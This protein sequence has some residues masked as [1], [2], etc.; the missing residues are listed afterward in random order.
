MFLAIFVEKL[1]L[2]RLGQSLSEQA[3]L[4]PV[5]ANDSTGK[6][7]M[8][9]ANAAQRRATLAERSGLSRLAEGSRLTELS[10]HAGGLR[11]ARC[12][13]VVFVIA[14]RSQ[15]IAGVSSVMMS[16]IERVFVRRSSKARAVVSKFAAR[17]LFSISDEQ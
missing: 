7:T 9:A 1:Y 6:E 8:N 13:V 11:R 16:R 17:A 15:L 5:P 10:V 2:V 14:S 3:S 4:M 12:F